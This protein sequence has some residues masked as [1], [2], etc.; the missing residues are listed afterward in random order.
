MTS[1]F[2]YFDIKNMTVL[3]V[4]V[5]SIYS[6]IQFQTTGKLKEKTI[7][8]KS[9][10]SVYLF[11]DATSR[12]LTRFTPWSI[13]GF[14]V[15]NLPVFGFPPRRV[16]PLLPRRNKQLQ[17]CRRLPFRDK[18]KRKLSGTKWLMKSPSCWFTAA[19]LFSTVAV[20]NCTDEC[21]QSA[22]ILDPKTC[23]VRKNK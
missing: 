13:Y 9:G 23:R 3:S 14:S 5:S 11:S 1:W 19:S 15:V 16:S 6:I 4:S 10:F 2:V 21:L 7:L 8:N 20:N 12:D 17:I 22:F 18:C